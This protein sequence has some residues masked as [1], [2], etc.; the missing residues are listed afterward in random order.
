MRKRAHS[1]SGEDA[2]FSFWKQEFDSPMGYEIREWRFDSKAV[3]LLL[4]IFT[5]KV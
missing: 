5:K 3:I 2:R 1:S 4:P